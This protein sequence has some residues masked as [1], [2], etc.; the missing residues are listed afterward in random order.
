M[1]FDAEEVKTRFNEGEQLEF[2][3]FWGHT[4]KPGIVRKTCLSQWYPCEFIVNG[5][6]YHTTEQYMM[7]QKALLFQDDETYNKI[8]GATHPQEYKALG[9]LVKNFD[10]E[11]WNKH[12]EEIVFQGNMAKFSQNEDLKTFLLSTGN[13]ILV[14]ASP[15][16]RVWGVRLAKDNPDILNPNNWRGENLLGKVLMRTREELSL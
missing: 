5:V 1:R 9:R 3:Y 15:Y 2:V 14:E 11:I 16:D 7:A 12:K 4:E 8:M 13:Q 6:T 10:E